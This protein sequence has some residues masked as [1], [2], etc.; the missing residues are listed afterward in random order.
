MRDYLKRAVRFWAMVGGACCLVATLL[1]FAGSVWWIFDLLAHFRVQCALGLLAAAAVLGATRRWVWTTACALGIAVNAIAIA[2]LV[3]GDVAP[4][5]DGPALRLVSFNV[6]TSN[7]NFAE[8]A[9]YLGEQNADMIVVNEIDRQ[10]LAALRTALDGYH[11]IAQPSS[12]N[13]GIGVWTRA[14][15][16]HHAVIQLGDSY[17]PAIEVTLAHA[18]TPF[19][20]LALHTL[21]PVSQELAAERDA[22]LRSTASWARRRTGHVA[23][24]GDLNA[25]PWSHG[26]RSL[27]ADANLVNSQRGHGLQTTWPA[28]LWPLS[29]PIDHCLHSR[30]LTAV[31][32]SV[33]P[34]LGSDHRPVIVDLA[35]AR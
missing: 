4:R 13:F 23:I 8:V 30:S 31:E 26:F 21:P 27:L 19:H 15:P 16:D 18:G 11:E 9:R 6:H 32:R 12:D 5:G 7:T 29:V 2:P 3:I 33:G 1:G 17:V 34:F 25:T 24:A 14:R 22:M 35:P 20:L 10:W 28:G